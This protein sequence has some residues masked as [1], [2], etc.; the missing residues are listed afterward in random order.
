MDKKLWVTVLSGLLLFQVLLLWVSERE[1][2]KEVRVPEAALVEAPSLEEQNPEEAGPLVTAAA[3]E[4]APVEEMTFVSNPDTEYFRINPDY[5]GWLRIG[6]TVI[7]YPV[8][9]GNDNETYLTRN[10]YGEEDVL[11]AIFMD[12]RNL[13]MGLDTHTIIYGH[14]TQHGQMFRDLEKYLRE[15]F[16]YA[17]PEFTFKNAYSE[18]SYRIFSVHVAP[19]ETSFLD[20]SFQGEEYAEFLSMLQNLSLFP[21]EVEVTPEDRILTL[22]TC[23]FAV[24][25]GRLFIH[26]V[27]VEE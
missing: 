1:Q 27:E 18:K 19:A 3:V 6:E 25:D 14:Y 2:R 26:A 21:T 20:I 8:V 10:F 24:E 12:Y 13:G 11:G 4:D 16:F 22:V 15:E 23:N 9:R 5:V 7:D 17:N